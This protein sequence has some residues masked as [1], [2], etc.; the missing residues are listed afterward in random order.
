MA[1]HTRN[2]PD[3][4]ETRVLDLTRRMLTINET[5]DLLTLSPQT[6]LRMFADHEL[7]AVRVSQHWRIQ[8]ADLERYLAGRTNTVVRERGSN[9]GW[10]CN[11]P[12]SEVVA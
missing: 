6:V 7:D 2:E 8:P 3:Q 12:G 5:A 10:Y 1:A 9:T 11:D 4:P